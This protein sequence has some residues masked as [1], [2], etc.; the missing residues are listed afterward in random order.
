MAEAA[1]R[2]TEVFTDEPGANDE[3]LVGRKGGTETMI[4][5]FRLIIICF[6]IVLVIEKILDHRE[7][8]R[9]IDVVNKQEDRQ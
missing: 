2:A 1:H 7:N 3:E 8:M 9:R 6:T 4:E 5:L